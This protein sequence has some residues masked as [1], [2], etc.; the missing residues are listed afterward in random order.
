MT[1]IKKNDA[2]YLNRIVIY[3]LLS[4][5]VLVLN[6]CKKNEASVMMDTSFLTIVNASPTIGTF[7]FYLNK[8]KVN[9]AALPFGGQVPYFN[10]KSGTYDAKFTTAS[11]IE[12]IITKRITVD[13][14]KAYSLFLIDTGDKI[15]YLLINDL[16]DQQIE[17]AFIRLI[18]LSPDAPAL[19]LAVENESIVISNKSYKTNSEFLE[20]APK[21][22]NFQIKNNE[23]GVLMAEL[24]G[25]NISKGKY[26][27]IISRGMKDAGENQQT[28]SAQLLENK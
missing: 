18:H 24:K 8:S 3:S 21:A 6:A 2:K 17:K 19:D 11:D 25:V 4:F 23:T 7:N 20:I 27:T 15:D 9:N 22:Y 26:Y 5:C 10:M 16:L 14:N 13:P 12:S 1:F 28:F